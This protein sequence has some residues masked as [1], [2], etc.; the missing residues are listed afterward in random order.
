VCAGEAGGLA[1]RPPDQNRG[2]MSWEGITAAGQRPDSH[3]DFAAFSGPQTRG[4]DEY[5]G[6]TRRVV[7]GGFEQGSSP[8][9]QRVCYL[10]MAMEQL[11]R[12]IE[13]RVL[14]LKA[15]GQTTAEIARR[16]KRGEDHIERIIGW[17]DIP[18]QPRNRR[19]DGLRPIE[20]RVLALRN[21]GLSHEE[22]GARFRRDAEFARRVESIAQIRDDLGLLSNT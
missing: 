19:R 22:I 18:R 1:R 7:S 14:A 12:P 20:R 8:L 5:I 10:R 9:P 6:A 17:T 21:D 15:S 13:R 4:F 2:F 11:L 16:F 3:R